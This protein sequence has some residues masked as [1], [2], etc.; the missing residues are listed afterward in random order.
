MT[1]PRTLSLPLALLAIALASS[2]PAA[3]PAAPRAVGPA[4]SPIATP[5][6]VIGVRVRNSVGELYDRRTGKRFVVRGANYLRL[7]PPRSG[8]RFDLL[9][10]PRAA[11]LGRVGQDFPAMRALGFNTVRI[12]LD[13][14]RIECIG[15]STG[16]NP[17]YLDKLARVLRFAKQAGI[18]L[19][20]TVNEWDGFV[21]YRAGI[22]SGTFGGSFNGLYL[23][24]EGIKAASLFYTDVIKGLQKRK[25]PLDAVLAWE[26]RNEQFFDFS[27]PPFTLSSGGVKTANGK[28]YELS[29]PAAKQRMMDEG[30]RFFVA[31]V[32]AA[33]K[34]V[35][36]TALVT[37]GFFPPQPPDD[38][39]I[40]RT[41][42]LLAASPLDFFDFHYYPGGITT[43]AEAVAG[44][45]MAGYERKPIVLGEYGAFK[46]AYPSAAE[47]AAALV[48]LQVESCRFGFDG[49]LYWFWTESDPELWVGP[50]AGG[51][52]NRGMSPK[53]RPDPCAYGPATLRDL[54]RGK[55]ARASRSLPGETP[56]RAVDGNIETG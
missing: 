30:I 29:D 56:D 33:I 42:P 28:T 5:R 6:H 14:C 45:G 11:N 27:S 24:S 39:R 20:P 34:R 10:D 21:G 7:Q 46:F 48:D 26:L 13:L 2:E 22:P 35:D 47:G 49:W 50:E 36:P 55:P 52:I 4:A 18:Y 53:E 37:M 15:S 38:P 51:A 43:L 40:V 54:A 32:K 25:A 17:A 19:L 16:L 41:A 8:D 44:F 31:R 3:E 23:T 12:F 9:L 1:A